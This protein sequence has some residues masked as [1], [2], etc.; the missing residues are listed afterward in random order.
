MNDRLGLRVVKTHTRKLPYI[1]LQ[2]GTPISVDVVVTVFVLLTKTIELL[3]IS[4]ELPIHLIPL[5][6][7]FPVI[8]A[9]QPLHLSMLVPLGIYIFNRL[10]HTA[11]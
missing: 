6:I 8:K 10:I 5:Q 3:C 4:R 2:E 7:R 11:G 9:K 1:P